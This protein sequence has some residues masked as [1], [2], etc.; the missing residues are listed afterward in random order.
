MSAQPQP[1]PTQPLDGL[2]GAGGF[3]AV[4]GAWWQAAPDGMLMLDMRGQILD[5]NPA[6]ARLLGR[7]SALLRGQPVRALFPD[8]DPAAWHNEVATAEA[9][10]FTTI[11]AFISGDGARQQIE[12]SA[13][14]L[15]PAQVTDSCDVAAWGVVLR[16]TRQQGAS[17]TA[18][19]HSEERYRAVV[20]HVSEGMLV[21]QNEVVVFANARAAEIVQMQVAE[22]QNIGF[23]HRVHPED[24][25]LV[26]E[27]QRRRLAGE[28]VNS[29]YEVRLLLPGGAVR[30]IAIG[31]SVVPWDGKP[32][33]LTFFTDITH[34]KEMLEAVRASEER[35]RAVLEHAGEGVV[36][37]H[38]DDHVGD[39]DRHRAPEKVVFVNRRALE[40]LRL[41]RAEFEQTSPR[42]LLH[43]EDFTRLREHRRRPGSG[44][45]GR[46]ELRLNTPDNSLLWIELGTAVVPWSETQA[47]MVFFTDITERKTMMAAL[48]R[49]EE[50]YRAVVEHV[51]EG[52][53]VVQNERFVFVNERATLITRMSRSEMMRQ[54]F[55]AAIHPDDRP[56]VLE[57]QRR[58]LAGLEVPNRYELRLQHADGS[59]TWVDIGVTLVPW[60]GEDATLTFFSDVTQRKTL[61]EQLRNT[62][63]ERETILENSLVGIAFLT[64][65]QVL[66]WSNRALSRIFGWSSAPGNNTGIPPLFPRAPTT[67]AEMFSDTEAFAAA[68]HAIEHSLRNGQVF[69]NEMQMRRA[70]G[71]LF[72][73]VVSA[74]AVDGNTPER[75]I[76]ATVLDITQ[77]KTLEEALQRT[78]SEREAIFNSALVGIVFNIARRIQ[79]VNHKCSEMLGYSA[80]DLVGKSTRVFY[81]NEASYQHDGQ[82]TLDNLRNHGHYTCERQLVRRNG[83]SFWVQLAGRCVVDRNPDAG[84]I[85]TL[86]DITERRNAEDGIRNALEQQKELNALRSRFVSMTSHE[87]RTP[88]A[89]I[90]SS[91]ELVKTYGA[92]LPET[93][94]LELLGS[95]EANVH[96]MT[97]MLDRMLLIGRADAQLLDFHPQD[98]DL[99][100][101]CLA[102]I[103]DARRQHTDSPNQVVLVYKLPSAKA[104]FDER[105]LRHILNNLLSNA[106]KYSPSGEQV[107]LQVHA[108]GRHT[109]FD[110]IDQGIGIPT[111]EIPHLFESFHRAS[112]VGNIQGTGLGLSIVK[113]AVER[114]GGKVEVRSSQHSGSHF[115]VTI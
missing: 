45:S 100:R 79:W 114:H 12:L 4:S 106:I 3:A 101:L 43:P 80:Q 46:L 50:R 109:V 53:V 9:A 65:R 78:S 28:V 59:I 47:T 90:L 11:L 31:V 105:L 51:G 99:Q 49:S 44:L 24:H 40:I 96:R 61:E 23:L 13:F 36:V 95:I 16:D 20:E 64:E 6:A 91:A 88:L 77:R 113:K 112:N 2:C 48:H 81:V 115:T 110:V 72:W 7:P 27:R 39:H 18:L 73:A 94:Q 70:D 15:P 103:D 29:H 35:Y 98:I 1:E 57:R 56:M 32:A 17:Q 55:L 97:R 37:L 52:M 89:T 67:W 93:E 19:R 8:A 10:T 86:L 25:A 26:L 76:V 87:F 102:C 58:R 104:S 84:V 21:I 108:I 14:A 38:Q 68:R 85:W 71:S 107:Q 62:L 33:S 60:D 30:W 92:R 34:N 75:G 54:G 41:T 83:E 5:S 82:V 111:H 42:Q 69:Q 63:G 22:M 74:K 66:R